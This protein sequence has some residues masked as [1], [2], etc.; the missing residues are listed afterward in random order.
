MTVHFHHSRRSQPSN[1]WPAQ[2][3][4]IIL[5]RIC[6]SEDFEKDNSENSQRNC[7]VPY[8]LSFF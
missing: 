7:E 3:A 8:I 6:L 1:K 2:S 5:T 4:E